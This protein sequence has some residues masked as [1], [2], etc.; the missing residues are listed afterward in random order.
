MS[1]GEENLKL[2]ELFKK[3]I[4]AGDIS[5]HGTVVRFHC[6]KCGH[7]MTGSRYLFNIAKNFP[8]QLKTIIC[9]NCYQKN[10]AGS[11]PKNK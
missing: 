10:L 8:E 4:E 2:R 11:K 7:S 6:T 9:Y 1:I 5:W 3:E